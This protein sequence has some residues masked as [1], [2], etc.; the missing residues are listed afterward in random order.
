MKSSMFM[1]LK[2]GYYVRKITEGI[3]SLFK[4]SGS[5]VSFDYE[6]QKFHNLSKILKQKNDT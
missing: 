6:H 3:F 1:K 5:K 2:S 4:K